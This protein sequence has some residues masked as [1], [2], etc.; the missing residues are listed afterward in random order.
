[1]A[2]D[3]QEQEGT[4]FEVALQRPLGA[5][6][7]ERNGAVCIGIVLDGGNAAQ[8]GVE[9]GDVVLATSASIGSQMWPKS[10]LEGVQS[11]IQT[12][13]D[14][15]VRLRLRRPA[16]QQPRWAQ[17]WANGIEQDYEVELSKPLGLILRQEKTGVGQLGAVE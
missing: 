4:V 11:A 2:E 15:V 9:E 6:L 5:S 3:A 17:P 10:T 14:G 13:V 8:A 12:R 7:Q 16:T 1:M